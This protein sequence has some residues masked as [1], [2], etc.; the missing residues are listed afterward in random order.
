MKHDQYLLLS[1]KIINLFPQEAKA[2][3]YIPYISRRNS[4][5]DKGVF[6]KGR[7]VDKVRNILYRS[8]DTVPHKRKKTD[9]LE[10]SATEDFE[11]AY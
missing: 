4:G 7:L 1:E 6:A 10:A 11:G 2:T 8:G 3:Y 5:S 9:L